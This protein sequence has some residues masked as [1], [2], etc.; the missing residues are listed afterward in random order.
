MVIPV[1]SEFKKQVPGFIHS[2]SA[3]GAT[4]FIEPAETLELNNELRELQLREQREIARI[5]R[6]LTAQVR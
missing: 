5:L 6:E 3:S 1:K 4:M 2:S